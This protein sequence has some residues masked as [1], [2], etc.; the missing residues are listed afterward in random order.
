MAARAKK[1]KA[2][3]IETKLAAITELERTQARSDI[4]TKYGI[5]VSMLS[6]WQKNEAKIKKKA[7]EGF[8]QFLKARAPDHPELDACMFSW[9]SQMRS[10]GAPLTEDSYSLRAAEFAAKLK[11]ENFKASSGWIESFK[12]RHK[13]QSKVC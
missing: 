11:I 5:D 2:Y 7:A 4:A 6:K 13:L 8:G 1:R 3:T 9:V 10:A 12:K